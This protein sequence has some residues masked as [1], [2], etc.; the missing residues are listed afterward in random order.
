[1]DEWICGQV[2]SSS[3]DVLCGKSGILLCL[4]LEAVRFRSVCPGVDWIER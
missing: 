1:V 3:K 2:G 4:Q